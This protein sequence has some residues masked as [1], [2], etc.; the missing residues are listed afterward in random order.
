M[1]TKEMFEKLGFKWKETEDVIEY[2][3]SLFKHFTFL[4]KEKII[5]YKDSYFRFFYLDGV[6]EVHK[7]LLEAINKQI[8]ELGWN[9]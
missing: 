2:T 8:E 1:S 7:Y 9:K 4:Q 5:F 6:Y 3:R